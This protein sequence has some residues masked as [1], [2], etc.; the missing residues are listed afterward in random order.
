MP[1][2]NPMGYL[3]RRRNSNSGA[4]QTK[5]GMGVSRNNGR[6]GPMLKQM[7]NPAGTRGKGAVLN[8][9]NNEKIVKTQGVFGNSYFITSWDS[10][11][12]KTRR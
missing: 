3:A 1:R 6:G 8:N 2:G 12:G 5:P 7:A 10:G 11:R 9:M 4:I